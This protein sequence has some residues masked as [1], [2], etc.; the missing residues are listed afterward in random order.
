M[1]K[2]E[3]TRKKIIESAKAI[4]MSKGVA[5]VPVSQ[6][7]QAA[8]VAKGTVYLYFDSKDD[9]VWAVI[10]DHLNAFIQLFKTIPNL[11]HDQEDIYAIIDDVFDFVEIHKDALKMIHQARFYNYF[12]LELMEEKYAYLWRDSIMVWL[13]KGMNLG[14]FKINNINFYCDFIFSSIHGMTDSYITGQA[15]Y[16]IDLIKSETKEILRR[17]LGR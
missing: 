8:G 14:K 7:A 10:E 6:I 9:I 2:S 11:G 12:G 16:S 4:F 17:L 13:E 1:K 15:D 5:E 3:Q